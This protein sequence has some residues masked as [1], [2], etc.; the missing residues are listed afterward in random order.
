[1][2]RLKIP[3]LARRS[4][5]LVEEWHQVQ[6]CKGAKPPAQKEHWLPPDQGWIKVN[7]DGAMIQ[8]SGHGGGGVVARDHD[9]RFLAGSSHFFPSLLDPEHVE[10]LAC[11]KAIEL[12]NSRQM[13]R[14]VFELDSA[15]VVS[16]LQVE[17][18]DRSVHGILIEQI[19]R[20][21]RNGR[22]FVVKWARRSA[23]EVAHRLAKEGCELSS[24][25]IWL[26]VSPDCIKNALYSDVARV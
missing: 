20:E 7:A 4:I 13:H 3:R 5:H 10:L 16:K 24:A 9:G 14:V 2:P 25:R 18:S 19:K 11:R 15:S 21:L 12:A 23:N 1:M 17:E 8:A 22:D 6:E 26:D